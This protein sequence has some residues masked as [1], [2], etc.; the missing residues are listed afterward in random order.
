MNFP[1]LIAD[2]ISQ[3]LKN[4]IKILQKLEEIE[5]RLPPPPMPKPP[6]CEHL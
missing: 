6:G 2:Q 1:T 3:I 5:K 4:Q